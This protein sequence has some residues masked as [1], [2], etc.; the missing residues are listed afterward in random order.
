MITVAVLLFEGVELMDF[1][2]PTEVFI[3]ADRGRAFRVVTVAESTLPLR[4]MGGIT[5][6]PDRSFEDAPKA[7]ILVVPGGDF[8]AIG[9]VGRQWLKRAAAGAEIV[10]SVCYGALLLAE[11][12]LLDNIEATT[13]HLAIA[14]LQRAAPTCRVVAGRRYVDGGRII[15]TAGVT[16]G[17]DGALRIVERVLGT[18]AAAWAA[19]EWMEHR[20]E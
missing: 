7:E 20:R 14:D 12:G 2:G 17:I 18:E 16:A 4:T 10:M 11:A 5:I 8:K 6:V 15:T 19:E 13:H 1:A 3:I 9:R